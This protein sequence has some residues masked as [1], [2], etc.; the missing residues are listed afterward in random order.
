MKSPLD[1]IDQAALQR[2]LGAID[3][4]AQA[5][6]AQNA[7]DLVAWIIDTPDAKTKLEYIRAQYATVYEQR[8]NGLG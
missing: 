2:R 7:L 8:L 3:S 6:A 4:F 5:A 1:P